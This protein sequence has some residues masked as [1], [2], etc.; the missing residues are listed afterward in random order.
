M[1]ENTPRVTGIGGVFLKVKDPAAMMEWYREHL[2]F[3]AAG[4][5]PWQGDSYIAFRWRD[6]K[7]PDKPGTTVWSVMPQDSD[8]FAPSKSATMLNYRVAD[9]HA[10]L[11]ALRAE[12][13]WVADKVDESELGKFGWIMDPEGNKIELWEPPA[14]A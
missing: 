5:D 7:D 12:G 14:G 6:D 8:Y 13:V 2:G 3:P 11:A 4:S 1:S 10:V 9:L